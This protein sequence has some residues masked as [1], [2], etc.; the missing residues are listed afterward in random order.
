[1]KLLKC[2]VR[3]LKSVWTQ[4]INL[5]T[6]F[7]NSLQY[8]YSKTWGDR[9]YSSKTRVSFIS[10]MEENV[11]MKKLTYIW[12]YVNIMVQKYTQMFNENEFECISGFDVEYVLG[13]RCSQCSPQYI[14]V[15]HLFA[16]WWTPTSHILNKGFFYPESLQFVTTGCSLCQLLELRGGVSCF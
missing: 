2:K 7:F 5:N 14:K 15:F 4:L 3:D 6:I 1:M 10:F 12:A 8:F 9:R 16:H 13:F 11:H